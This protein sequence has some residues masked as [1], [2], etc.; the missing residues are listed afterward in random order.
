[1]SLGDVA[2]IRP[3][4][5]FEHT[6]FW[7]CDIIVHTKNS[8]I[9]NDVVSDFN[10]TYGV[11]FRKTMSHDEYLYSNNVYTQEYKDLYYETIMI[12]MML[13]IIIL[14]H[15]TF[16]KYKRFAIMKL[17]GVSSVRILCKYSI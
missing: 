13:Y 3:W 12:I 16:F 4:Y 11:N 6:C 2:E 14:V 15:D 9:I 10:N 1:M 5:A 8:K 7:I 17:N